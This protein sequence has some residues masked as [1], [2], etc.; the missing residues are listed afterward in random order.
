MGC[1][2]LVVSRCI[3]IVS[4][5]EERILFMRRADRLFQIIQI[6][7]SARRPVTA[8][9]IAEE[10]RTSSRTIYRDIADLVAQHIPIRGE[11]GIGYI[12]D[13]SYE[14]PPLMLTP[15]EIE[16]AVLGARWVASQ[17]DP[18]LAVGARDLIGKIRAVIPTHLQHITID[19]TTM[20][21]AL[22]P[23]PT[24]AIDIAKVRDWIRAQS[25]I[26][27]RYL[28][29]KN[30]VSDRTIWPIAVAY[31]DSV[32][33]IVAW[34]ELRRT[35]RHFRTDRVVQAEFLTSTFPTAVEEL[36]KAWWNKEFVQSKVH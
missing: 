7:R 28:N 5:A 19:D 36:R 13:K 3:H 23:P 4:I 6:L 31:F 15:N 12:I 30:V 9:A 24:D 18:T 35:Y 21:P 2:D 16:A 14:M 11:A 22:T 20:V 10:L 25:K 27:I 32:R 1:K 34:C 8:V 17:G 29:E 33:L 26:R